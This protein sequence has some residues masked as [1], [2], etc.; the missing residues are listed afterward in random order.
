[1]FVYLGSDVVVE[2]SEILGIFDI[3][4]VTVDRYMKDYLNAVQKKGMVYYVSLDMPKCFVVCT[5]TVYVTNVS[6]D[7][8]KKRFREAETAAMPP[9]PQQVS[10]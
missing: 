1:M 10:L 3:E 5:D 4:R 7:T 2:D 8:I 6:G 9:L